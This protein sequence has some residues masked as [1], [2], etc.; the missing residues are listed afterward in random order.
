MAD[1]NA[2]SAFGTFDKLRDAYM[3][4]YDTPFGLALPQLQ[5]ERRR[6]LDRDGGVYREPLLEVRPEYATAARSLLESVAAARGAEELAEF[7]QR[8]L[9]PKGRSLYG[10]QEEALRAGVARDGHMVITA[11]TGSGKT[12]SFMLPLLSSLLEESRSW[13]PTAYRQ[14]ARWWDSLTGK[15]EP[16][17][18]TEELRPAAARAIVLYPMNALVEDQLVRMRRALDSDPVRAWLNEYRGG[19][20]FYF[21]RYTGATPVSGD[22]GNSSRLA[23][24]R[25]WMRATQSR[26]ARAMEIADRTGDDD[27]RYFVPRFDGAEMRSRWDMLTVPPDILI[28]NYSMLNVMLLRDRDNKF[29]NSTAQWLEDPANRFTLVVDELHSYRG[30]AGSEV[31]YLVRALKNRLGL[32]SRPEQ[33][34]V[35]AASASLTPESDRAYLESFFGVDGDAF[36]FVEGTPRAAKAVDITE[37]D[38]DVIE[39]SEDEVLAEHVVSRQLGEAFRFH[40]DG[41][42][43]TARELA[44]RLFP[45]AEAERGAAAVRKLVATFGKLDGSHAPR[46]RAHLFFRNVAGMWACSDP[47]CTA[48][49]TAPD[50]GRTVGRLFAEPATRCACG[51]R[52]LELLYCQTC[53][54]VFLGGFTAEGA[55]SR[56]SVDAHLLADVPELAK[57]PD[58]ATLSRTAGNYVV[59]WPRPE[60]TLSNLDNPTWKRTSSHGKHKADFG[61]VRSVYTPFDGRLTNKALGSTGWSFHVRPSVGGELDAGDL[62]PFPNVCPACGDDWELR[63]VPGKGALALGDPLRQRS[64]IRTMRTGFEKVNQILTTELINELPESE[65]KVVVFTDSRQDAAKLSSGMSLRHYQDL[66]RQILIEQTRHEPLSVADIDLA[67]AHLSPETRSAETLAATNRLREKNLSAYTALRDIWDGVEAIG[68]ELKLHAAFTSPVSL[69]ELSQLVFRELLALGVNPGGPKASLQSSAAEL[70]GADGG[71]WTELFDWSGARPRTNQ[72]LSNAQRL[73]L[74]K[75][76]EELKREVID[77]L[78]SGA[79]RDVE[80]LGLGWLTAV[81]DSAPAADDDLGAGVIRASLR[82]LAQLKRFTRTRDGRDTPPARLKKHW[83]VVAAGAGTD[84]DAIEALFRSRSSSIV[85][86]YLIDP[87]QVTLRSAEPDGWECARC[88]RP[89]LNRGAG[90]CTRCDAPLPGTAASL[91]PDTDYYAWKALREDG[92]FRLTTAELTGQTDRID[93][94]TRQARFQDVFLDEEDKRTHGIDLLSVTTTMEAGVDIGALSAV[95][96]G[97]MPPTRFNYQQRVGRAGRRGSPVAV[98]LTVCRGRSHDEHYF[99]HPEQITNAPTPPPQLVLDRPQLFDRALRSGMLRRA[100][101]ALAEAHKDIEWTT[102]AHGAFGHVSD[103]HSKLREP[104]GEWLAHNGESVAALAVALADRSAIDAA[105]RA[106]RVSLTLVDDIDSATSGV[107][108]EDLSQRLAERG[109]LPMFGFPTGVRNLYLRRPTSGSEWPPKETVDR[110]EAMAVSQFSPLSEIVRDGK[111][112]RVVGFAQFRP[113]GPRVEAVADPLGPARPLVLCQQCAYVEEVAELPASSETCPIC[114]AA[115]G[116]FRAVRMHSPLGYRAGEKPTDFDG[117]FSWSTRAMAARAHTQ[118][119]QLESRSVGMMKVAYGA[120]DRY[121]VNDNGGRQFSVRH[122]SGQSPWRGFVSDAAVAAGEL[123]SSFAAGEPFE[124]ALGT[125]QASDFLFVGC[126]TAVLDADGLR[127]DLRGGVR[128]L[129]G[130]DEPHQGRRA[131]W[132]SLA[133]LLRKVGATLL[134]VNPLEFNAGIYTTQGPA[135]A[136]TYAFL[137]DTL[138][139][140]AGFSTQLGGASF[141]ALVEAVTGAIEEF[142]RP[143]HAGLCAASCYS[144]LRDFGNLAYHALLDWRLARD[145]WMTLSTGVLEP[146][147]ER[148]RRAITT[149]ARAVDGTLMELEGVAAARYVSRKHGGSIVAIAKHPLEAIEDA[150]VQRERLRVAFEQANFASEPPVAVLFADTFSLDRDPRLVEQMTEQAVAGA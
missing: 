13:A 104:L 119:A 73:L 115:P 8:G 131:A 62:S 15:F 55:A 122:A 51:A 127:L 7:A 32:S 59:Y 28:T 138:E 3:R 68:D 135:G 5:E 20:R 18:G 121:T 132:F 11:G 112:H 34:R 113:V 123:P 114:G 47:N 56:A 22:P 140:G 29:F 137:A 79:G 82:I 96:M 118:L 109:L 107:G 144:C 128:Q 52:V 129:S 14:E 147:V 53:G 100:M 16:Q 108:H 117:Q 110:D 35:L 39:A 134:D 69:A 106:Q 130:C 27:I 81:T 94:Q 124:I 89:H 146:D 17:R 42:A 46:L 120:G 61:F 93:A 31:A 88:K 97:N 75:I 70:G 83:G 58:Q 141:D 116:P 86:E 23:E 72:N 49:E 41:E 103:W 26:S 148:E 150:G 77:A 43:L 33:F 87:A 74:E 48:M 54:D 76:E 19:N 126:E 24:L 21:G 142:E 92:R 60:P 145:L 12:E 139:N 44:Q 101:R 10:H 78:F 99:Q 2:V 65:R 30:T 9:L 25:R 66:L 111:V 64:P 45:S 40:A 67:R 50:P 136:A 80:S 133:F 6:L 37:T 95:V 98:A 85:S 84:L 125:R 102:N 38:L 63:S 90:M 149:W 105:A 57:L 4:Y 36:T 71:H 1:H 91:E 143:D